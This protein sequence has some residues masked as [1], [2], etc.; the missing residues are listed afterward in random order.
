MILSRNVEQDEMTFACKNDNS[1]LLLELTQGSKFFLKVLV[2]QGKCFQIFSS[3][4]LC[5]FRAYVVTQSLTSSS[6]SISASAS[7]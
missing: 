5:P 6:A 3:P 4:G 2:L 1:I 7:A